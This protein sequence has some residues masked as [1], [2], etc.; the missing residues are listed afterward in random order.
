MRSQPRWR[1]LIPEEGNLYS[2]AKK[3]RISEKSSTSED[4]RRAAPVARPRRPAPRDFALGVYGTRTSKLR[5]RERSH[6]VGPI[7]VGLGTLKSLLAH[8]VM[9]LTMLITLRC[10]LHRCS[11]RDV[12]R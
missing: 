8:R 10:A 7:P 1:H 12:R 3:L 11:S 2:G 6:M 9:Q 4:E 5:E